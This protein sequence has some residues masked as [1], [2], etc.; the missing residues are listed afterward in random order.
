MAEGGGVVPRVAARIVLSPEEESCLRHNVNSQTVERRLY[1]RSRIVLLAAEGHEN[2]EIGRQLGISEKTCRKWRNRFVQYRMEGLSD[3]QRSGAPE[4]FTPQE[5]L[6]I[7]RMSCQPPEDIR[8]WTL[9]ELT[10]QIRTRFQRE[11]SVES[12]R[13][14]LRSASAEDMEKIQGE[15]KK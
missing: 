14:I 9:A 8:K 10:S 6:E 15:L 2:I 7:L 13:L 12:I 11:V 3:L 5:R 1:L 4:K